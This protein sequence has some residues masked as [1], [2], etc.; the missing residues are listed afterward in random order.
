METEAG[1]VPSLETTSAGLAASR[2]GERSGVA[3][4]CPVWRLGGASHLPLASQ[5]P[6]EPDGSRLWPGQM[7]AGWFK[8]HVGNPIL[9][10]QGVLLNWP[11]ED[12]ITCIAEVLPS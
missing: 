9:K 11:G 10:T 7:R 2:P 3:S 1:T 5:E 12:I 4:P 8:L 6:R